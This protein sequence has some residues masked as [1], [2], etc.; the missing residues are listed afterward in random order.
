[1]EPIAGWATGTEGHWRL[2]CQAALVALALRPVTV[3]L[4]EL[5]PCLPA[6]FMLW[7]FHESFPISA[8]WKLKWKFTSQNSH[9]CY[10]ESGVWGLLP[11]RPRAFPSLSLFTSVGIRIRESA[12]S[13][14]H[15]SF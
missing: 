8:G 1:M 3:G 4:C 9:I 13:G 14:T 7:I 15:G 11:A 12:A 10:L 6:N 5:S 2:K